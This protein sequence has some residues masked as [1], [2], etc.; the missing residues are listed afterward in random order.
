MGDFLFREMIKIKEVI[1]IT[2]GAFAKSLSFDHVQT[3]LLG[4]HVAMP[5]KR[6]TITKHAA[7]KLIN[8]TTER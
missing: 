2:E 5:G 7:C 3:I 8:G 4:S 6:I 1:F